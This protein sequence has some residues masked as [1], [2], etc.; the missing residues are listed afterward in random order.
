MRANRRERVLDSALASV[1]SLYLLFAFAVVEYRLPHVSICPLLL[2]AGVPCP[3]CGST[4]TIGGY[5]HGAIPR[6]WEQVPSMVWFM[7]VV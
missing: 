1:S 7:F 3:L 2:I 6:G 4:R 5:L